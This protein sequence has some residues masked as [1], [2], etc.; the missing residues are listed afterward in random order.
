MFPIITITF[1]PCIDKS[2]STEKITPDRKLPCSQ[3]RIDPGGGGINVARAVRK[4]GGEALAVFPA[5]GPHGQLLTQLLNDE[6]VPVSPIWV[7]KDTREN[8]NVTE[9]S[10]N[11]QFRFVVQ[12]PVL[13]EAAWS[14]CLAGLDQLENGGYVVVSGSL[15]EPWPQ[16]IFSRIKKVTADRQAH[17][18]VDTSGGAL[19]T[20][21]Q[22]GVELIKPSLR[23]LDALARAMGL[24]PGGPVETARQL[25][26]RGLAEGVVISAGPDGAILVAESG[27]TEIPALQ[28]PKASTVGA[29]DSMV[30][31]IVLQLAR[32]KPL[33]DAVRYG[34][35]CGTAAVMNPGTSLCRQDDADELYRR[36]CDSCVSWRPSFDSP[37]SAPLSPAS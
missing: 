7:D 4:L 20:A 29:G 22:C 3:L 18:V 12:G 11:R 30:G 5:G 23:E 17:V 35:A 10:T 8:I 31:G 37:A 15:P 34:V 36:M 21:V 13:D 16:D 25:V 9:S 1:N 14:R 19:M 32:G 24:Q 6:R 26:S 27:V 28:V 2:F 33:A